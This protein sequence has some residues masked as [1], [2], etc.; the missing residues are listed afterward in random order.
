MQTE[1]AKHGGGMWRSG[2]GSV[3]VKWII[4]DKRD[5]EE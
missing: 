1:G 3:V 2:A 4:Q 5:L